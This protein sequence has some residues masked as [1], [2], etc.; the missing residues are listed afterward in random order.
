MICFYN[1]L[2]TKHPG[3]LNAASNSIVCTD[4]NSLLR[5]VF[6]VSA[7]GVRAISFPSKKYKALSARCD[8]CLQDDQ[9]QVAGK[10]KTFTVSK[11]TPLITSDFQSRGKYISILRIEKGF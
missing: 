2:Q 1:Y 7:L 3:L 11:S 6:N 8:L 10:M 4:D 5:D 9:C